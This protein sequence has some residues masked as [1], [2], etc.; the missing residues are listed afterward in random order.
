MRPLM[1]KEK[2]S[3]QILTL[4][5]SEQIDVNGC[6]LSFY[7]PNNVS[8]FVSI[9]KKEL[10]VSKKIYQT[11]VVDKTK[12]NKEVEIEGR[13]LSKLYNYLEHIQ[14]SIICIYTA[15]EALANVA[16]PNNYEYKTKNSKG[17]SETWDKEAIERWFKTSDKYTKLIPS[18]LEIETP[19]TKSFWS[20]FKELEVIRNEIIHQKTSL[21]KPT[22]VDSD[23]L[24][25]LLKSQIFDIVDSGFELISYVCNS[26]QTHAFFP[27]GFG[28]AQIKIVELDSFTDNFELVK[29]AKT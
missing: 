29:K 12:K 10:L 26:D 8:I 16:I 5:Q 22:D 24:N 1:A 27:L 3:S 9:A 13:D 21:K 25:K 18:I 6:E 14:T 28:P 20:K 7:A 15:I 2:S 11:V 4:Q 17:V 19:S 23:Y